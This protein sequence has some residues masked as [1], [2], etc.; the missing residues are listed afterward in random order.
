MFFLIGGSAGELA[1]PMFIGLVVDL[2]MQDKGLEVISTYICYMLIL[3]IFSGVCVGMRA[4]IYNILS[5]RIA[6]NLR[7]DFYDNLV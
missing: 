4:A 3:V 5:E 7:K 2:L 1:M 6:R